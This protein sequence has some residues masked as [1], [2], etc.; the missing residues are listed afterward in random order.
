VTKYQLFVSYRKSTILPLNKSRF[1]VFFEPHGAKNV[2]PYGV[3][4]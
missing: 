2:E 1:A 3:F 4:L